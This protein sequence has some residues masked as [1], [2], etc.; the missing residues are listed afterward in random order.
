MKS[1][2]THFSGR[3]SAVER[4]HKVGLSPRSKIQA[5]TNERRHRGNNQ[6]W[7]DWIGQVADPIGPIG[8]PC[9]LSSLTTLG[10]HTHL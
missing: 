5:S 9:L 8:S 10:P 2:E 3:I 1:E 4:K 7:A 6:V